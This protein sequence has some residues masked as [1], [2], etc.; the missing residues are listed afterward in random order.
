VVRVYLDEDV[1]VL[2]AELLRARGVD[3]ITARDLSMLGKS[4]EEHFQKSV[5]LERIILTHNRVDFENLYTSFIEEGR[6]HEGVIVL[7]RKRD[8]YNT[9]HRL[10]HFFAHHKNTQN[11]LWYL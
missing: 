6:D 9:A 10:I 4:D 3:A 2:I 7:S 1:S 8:V 5:E 11:Q